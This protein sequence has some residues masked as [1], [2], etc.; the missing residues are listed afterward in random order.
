MT[1]HQAKGLEWDKVVVSVTPNR[2]DKIV[3][4]D[5]YSNPRLIGESPADEFTRMYYV[6]CSRARE[7]LY[8]HLP[9][10]SIVDKLDESLHTFAEK[11]GSGIEYEIIQ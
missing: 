9:D 2:F 10:I 8:I 11:T 5:I 4:E 3:I 6:A 7:D 1:V